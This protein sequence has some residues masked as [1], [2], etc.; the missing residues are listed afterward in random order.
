M[1][2]RFA[3]GLKKD[4]VQLKTTFPLETNYFDPFFKAVIVSFT[5]L[6]GIVC[7]RVVA[8]FWES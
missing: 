6:P 1:F 4:K 7:L 2:R 3:I 5:R 8:G